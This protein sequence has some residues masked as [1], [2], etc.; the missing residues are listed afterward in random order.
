ML[1]QSKL[2]YGIAKKFEAL[3]IEVS[4]LRFIREAGMREGF[5]KQKRITKFIP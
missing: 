3:I 5:R 1:G 2:Q 4:L